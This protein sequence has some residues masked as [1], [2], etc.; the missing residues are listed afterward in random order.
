M[1][2]I[3]P[4]GVRKKILIILVC[5]IAGIL[6][7][8]VVSQEDIFTAKEKLE[9]VELAY[10]LN[11]IILEVRRYEKNFL[12]YGT[13]EALTENQQQLD[14]ALETVD[15]I[16]ARV[17][18]LKVHPM[19]IGLKA[20]LLAYQ[21]DV[22]L[23]ANMFHDHGQRIHSEQDHNELEEKLRQ[24]GQDMTERSKELVSFEHL[25]IL[26]ILNALVEQLL[27]WSLVAIAVGIFIPLV[28]SINIFR[29]LGIIKKATEDIAVGQF[30][31]IE[32]LNTRDE[33]Q[34]VMEAFNTMVGELERRQDQLVQ[35]QKL[36]S[37][38][39]LTAG[40]AH[41]LNNPLNNISTSCQI[42]TTEFDSGD[43][44][45]VRR[46]L[47][48]IEQETY[49]ARDVVQGLLEFS[50]TREFSL[51]PASLQETVARAVKLVRSQVPAPVAITVD[52]PDN[53]IVPM[54]V[55]RLQEVLLNMLINASQAIVGEGSITISAE[56][57]DVAEEAIVIVR[58]TGS[59]IPE[60]IK[61][62]L[63]D[64]FYT[65]KEEGQGTGLGLSIA[66]GIIQKHNGRIT[67]ESSPGEGAAFHIHLPLS[68][69]SNG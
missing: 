63:F 50:R 15:I 66:Y 46:M 22:L 54:D 6:G 11:T 28:M 29:P 62:R 18:T 40:I 68:A 55:Q 34:Q 36:S 19:L 45:L 23:M 35:S 47:N 69:V 30:R 5:Y 32:V 38:G 39:T 1:T 7:M 17:A 58:D 43:T 9:V 26:A 52:I 59:G 2:I 14:K 60:E 16:N 27:L 24:E 31:R 67:V 57:D 25:Q 13:E 3:P 8:S 4:L 42:A 12:L 61:D 33:M 21:Q 53:L 49:R 10:S 44:E 56:V 48:N 41:Q 65:T 37:I 64:P 51:R 20:A